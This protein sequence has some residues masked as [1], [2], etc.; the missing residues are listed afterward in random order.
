MASEILLNNQQQKKKKRKEGEEEKAIF[1]S[2]RHPA[3]H[4]LYK[5]ESFCFLKRGQVPADERE[6]TA[7]H[8]HLHTNSELWHLFFFFASGKK[9][10][11]TVLRS[12]KALLE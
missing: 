2:G 5:V 11:F 10:W 6:A 12:R 1:A 9:S 7:I 8:L 4:H 3:V